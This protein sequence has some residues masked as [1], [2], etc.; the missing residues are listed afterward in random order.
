MMIEPAQCRD[1][2]RSSG[3]RFTPPHGQDAR[4]TWCLDNTFPTNHV[5]SIAHAA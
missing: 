5:Q 3:R 2:R 4:A 1:E